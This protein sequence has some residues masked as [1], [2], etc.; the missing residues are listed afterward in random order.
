M[1]KR[2][3]PCTLAHPHP[4]PIPNGN[5]KNTNKRQKGSEMK[6]LNQ[7]VQKWP[8]SP[9]KNATLNTYHPAV[10][11]PKNLHLTTCGYIFLS[12]MILL[13]FDHVWDFTMK[14]I[15]ADF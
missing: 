3:G 13:Y 5:V 8:N 1:N 14:L 6:K 11:A 4:L 15:T 10:V 2:R 12:M 9:I 7:M